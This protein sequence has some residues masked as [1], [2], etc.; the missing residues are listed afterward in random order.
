MR[1]TKRLRDYAFIEHFVFDYARYPELP[2]G[3]PSHWVLLRGRAVNL[4]VKVRTAR[5]PWESGWATARRRRTA[6]EAVV[7]IA[8]LSS[9]ARLAAQQ[10]ASRKPR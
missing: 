6:A 7:R 3:G 8:K 5:Q 1:S 9:A 10:T 4:A 2:D